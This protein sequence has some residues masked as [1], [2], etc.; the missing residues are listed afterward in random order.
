MKGNFFFCHQLFNLLSELVIAKKGTK[1]CKRKFPFSWCLALA[2]TGTSSLCLFEPLFLP[3][4]QCFSWRFCCWFTRQ[5]STLYLFFHNFSLSRRHV[6][7]VSSVFLLVTVSVLVLPPLW[8]HLS[9]SCLSTTQ[10][11]LPLVQRISCMRVRMDPYLLLSSLLELLIFLKVQPS[12]VW[13]YLY[14]VHLY[15]FFYFT[16][17]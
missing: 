10:M 15:L 12:S 2:L 9:L 4:F 14:Y 13:N 17:A 6:S 5:H 1:G 11:G 3:F 16:P 8:N 7:F